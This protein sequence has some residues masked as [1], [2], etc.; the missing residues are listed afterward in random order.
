MPANQNYIAP[1]KGF[2]APSIPLLVGEHMYMQ[3]TG[4]VIFFA[5]IKEAK[6]QS[7]TLPVAIIAALAAGVL[8]A[9]A[10]RTMETRYDKKNIELHNKVAPFKERLST[11]TNI[12]IEGF[13]WQGIP[14]AFAKA[15]DSANNENLSSSYQLL[16]FAGAKLMSHLSGLG[17]C[18]CRGE[19]R[20]V[21]GYYCQDGFGEGY[22]YHYTSAHK[23]DEQLYHV[24]EAILAIVMMVGA[25]IMDSYRNNNEFFL[26]GLSIVGTL[27][28]LKTL[29][30][31]AQIWLQVTA[32]MCFPKTHKWQPLFV[33]QNGDLVVA[34]PV[35]PGGITGE[36]ASP[37]GEENGDRELVILNRQ[38]QPDI[39]SGEP[40]GRA[41]VN[42][43]IFL[44][45]RI[46]RENTA[47]AGL[48]N[49]I[50]T[51]EKREENSIISNPMDGV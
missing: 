24:R 36:L 48:T 13:L 50:N 44:R 14:L 33:P 10:T 20:N 37:V 1:R 8:F 9:S 46:Q 43:L 47:P 15:L 16:A 31:A 25:G 5:L 6:K 17:F 29:P 19:A 26:R 32:S 45:Q 27:Y 49:P 22:S 12:L 2:Y 21:G 34:N 30:A 23:K 41:I 51:E 40:L 4:A 28:L 11:N 39:I 38:P 3:Y 35:P 18:C 42:S 7:A